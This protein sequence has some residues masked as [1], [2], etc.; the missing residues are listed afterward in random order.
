MF[1]PILAQTQISD[2]A[3]FMPDAAS[4]NH[5]RSTTPTPT[6]NPIPLPHQGW[7]HAVGN[8]HRLGVDHSK[9]WGHKTG[10]GALAP[11]LPQIA[12]LGIHSDHLDSIVPNGWKLKLIICH[13]YLYG[14]LVNI[15]GSE[16]SL[17]LTTSSFAKWF[18]PCFLFPSQLFLKPRT[19]G[20][21]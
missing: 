17:K 2:D 3:G 4:T 8:Y 15:N 5:F 14:N 10:K 19:S 6:R 9:V 20:W 16:R 11:S 1:I 21:S 7:H 12:V 18:T 13:T